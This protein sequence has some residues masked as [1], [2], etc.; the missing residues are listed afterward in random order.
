MNIEKNKKRILA[1]IA[2]LIALIAII[3]GL[4]LGGNKT[5]DQSQVTEN[6]LYKITILE[7][8]HGSVTANKSEAKEGEEIVLTVTPEENYEL[9]SLSVNQKESETTFLMPAEDVRVL[10]KFALA[11]GAENAMI[12]GDTFGSAEGY[13]TT[14]GVD[15]S[16]DNGENPYISI[17]AGGPQYAYVKNV[18][19]D[20]LVFETT[21]DVKEIFNDD[22]YPKFGIMLNG[23][24]EMVKFFVD[25]RPDM[26]CE[27]VGVVHQPTGGEDDWANAYSKSIEKL[28]LADQEI[29]LKV[30][31]DGQDY[32]FYVNNVMVL[33]EKGALCNEK[34]AVGVFS[35]NTGLEAFGYR[36]LEDDM[37]KAEIAQAKL[38]SYPLMG[39]FFGKS[40]RFVSSDVIDFSTDHGEYPYL[41]LD[42]YKGTPLYTYINDFSSKQYYFEIDATVMNILDSEK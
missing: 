14:E 42:A 36:H 32:Y 8:A 10:A 24:T 5:E 16:N 18:Y 34:T 25:L 4:F 28:N 7:S 2:A 22:A 40:G 31:R 41:E 26:T 35:F 11:E 3:A 13:L 27:S 6:G 21:F 1:G 39:D 29:T 17:V 19:A 9:T 38:D 37:A 30:V 33:C 12:E 20:R 15:L 23:T